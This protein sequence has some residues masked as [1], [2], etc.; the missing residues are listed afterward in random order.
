MAES[1]GRAGS[2]HAH[3]HDIGAEFAEHTPE[4]PV[5]TGVRRAVQR[6]EA[7]RRTEAS[8]V[9]GAVVPSQECAA[10]KDTGVMSS[11][12]ELLSEPESHDFGATNWG[13]HVVD[14]K[15]LQSFD[16]SSSIRCPFRSDSSAARTTVRLRNPS[17][18]SGLTDFPPLTAPM[19]AS[20][21]AR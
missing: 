17:S 16:T 6:P 12:S 2:E 5:C 3:V 9:G 21:A 14:E 18:M 4:L 19:K 7:G 10:G 1:M 11:S 8:I 15:D 20:S 13:G